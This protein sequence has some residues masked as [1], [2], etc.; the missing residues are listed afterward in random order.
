MPN[1]SV[2][3]VS[4]YK[5]SF[6]DDVVSYV[7]HGFDAIGVWRPKLEEYGI[8]KGIELLSD[9]GLRVSSL[10]WAGGFTGSDGRSFN[11]SVHDALD[12]ID[13]AAQ[14]DAECLVVVVGDRNGHTNRHVRRVLLQALTELTEAASA[15]HIDIAIEPMHAGS[16]SQGCFLNDIQS[17]VEVIGDIGWPGIGIVFD[18]YHLGH[19][20]RSVEW[21]SEI[22]S[23][24]RL[25][26]L[27]DARHAPMG[28]QDRCLLGQGRLPLSNCIE[29][30]EEA[31]YDGFFELELF[32]ESVEHLEYSQLLSHSKR[33]MQSLIRDKA[34][35]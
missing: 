5:W 34:R 13:L 11:E 29:A 21:L 31:G 30:L 18:S 23:L 14:L 17:T 10:G 15:L 20:P 33:Q 12:A 35:A 2:N 7:E 27:G 6:D 9:S 24:I 32:G 8:E 16:G 22:A 26:Q 1:L 3:E 4:T 19:D 25:V 28:E